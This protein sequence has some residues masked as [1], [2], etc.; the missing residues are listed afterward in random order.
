[1][2]GVDPLLP[3]NPPRE[4]APTRPVRP[5]HPLFVISLVTALIIGWIAVSSVVFLSE[6]R[7]TMLK[8]AQTNLVHHAAALGEQ[9]NISWESLDLLLSS[10]GDYVGRQGVTDGASYNR[11]M[12]G[13]DTHLLFRE[14]ISG[15]PF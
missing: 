6:L 12:G 4:K 14:K 3:P 5:Y 15:L 1:M 9:A 8:T 7:E 2:A 13:H 10:L 11:T